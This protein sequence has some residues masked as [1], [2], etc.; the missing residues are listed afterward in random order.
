MKVTRSDVARAAG[1]AP[2]TV[3]YVLNNS[4]QISEK[5]RQKVM[6]AVE[7]LNY[8]PDLI[9]RGLVTNQTM[10][11]ALILSDI[12]NPF[13]GEIAR[14]FEQSAL[15][16]GYFVSI[17][18]G[19]GNLDHYLEN[20]V[21]RHV[22]GAVIFANPTHYQMENVKKL[23][24][25]DIKVVIS[26]NQVPDQIA[27]IENDYVSGMEQA[28]T[29]LTESGHRRIAYFSCFGNQVQYDTRIDGFK[30][31]A[32][33]LGLHQSDILLVEGKSPYYSDLETGKEMAQEII[34]QGMPVTAAVCT[35]D[36]MALGA[37]Q[38]FHQSGIKVPEDIS[39]IGCD[40]IM[41]ASAMI[42]SLTT[43][44]IDKEKLGRDAFALLYRQIKTGE[45]KHEKVTVELKVRSTT[46][47][48]G[49]R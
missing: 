48:P 44:G 15:E 22:D 24:D 36:L 9:A 11:L 47:K 46:T 45:I 18:S 8:Q 17:C 43:I 39:V 42:P 23:V 37:I 41:L 21:R 49:V 4:R 31:A 27:S 28:L 2:A 12:G 1:V 26:G 29:H 3:S 34:R 35:N 25:N 38:E 6:D 13:Y 7:A 33:K 30:R 19:E 5:T 16:K 10:Q 32:N 40:D 14:A 20:L